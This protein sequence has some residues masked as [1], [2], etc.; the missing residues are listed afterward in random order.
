MVEVPLTAKV[1]AC[2]D[3]GVVP[4]DAAAEGG[5]AVTVPSTA[6]VWLAGQPDG[7]M[8]MG[9]PSPVGAPDVAP[10]N[11][12]IEVSVIAGSTLTFSVTG[13]T[14]NA[15]TLCF[16]SSPDGGGCLPDIT[17]AATNGLGSL[18]S[19]GDALI[20]VFLDASVPSGTAPAGLTLSTANDGFA[21]LSPLL[22][23][24]FFIGDG[25]TGT[26]TAPRSDSWSQ[27]APRACCSETPTT[28][29]RTTTTPVNSS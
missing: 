2:P 7:T 29:E 9:G 5:L 3:G 26:G 25:L 4:G 27:P 13:T 20:A 19:P 17:M 11:S 28:S 15:S 8:L 21:T 22:R 14:S 12:P 6:D 10:T 24:V 23:Q 1:I 18:E 16:A